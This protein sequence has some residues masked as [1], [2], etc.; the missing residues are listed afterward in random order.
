MP[1]TQGW[2]VCRAKRS[3]GQPCRSPVIRGAR[4]CRMHGG[5]TKHVKDAAAKRLDELV[6]PSFSLAMGMKKPP[7]TGAE[8]RPRERSEHRGRRRLERLRDLLADEAGS[9]PQ[10]L[11]V[12][13]QA[14]D[15]GHDRGDGER[16][17][18]LD[19]VGGRVLLRRDG[20]R[21]G[22]TEELELH[23]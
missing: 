6:M 3:D 2:L 18:A 21:G 20:I 17:V 19:A 7:R 5:S 23:T 13:G 4:V 22:A 14:T 8:A 1:G 15:A 16:A 11:V 12:S 10:E 9:L